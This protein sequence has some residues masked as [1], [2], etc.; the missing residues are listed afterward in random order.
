MLSIWPK[1]PKL[2]TAQH[3]FEN[4]FKDQINGLDTMTVRAGWTEKTGVQSNI[5]TIANS[6]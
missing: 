1:F 2:P 3:F 5:L 4:N 6:K